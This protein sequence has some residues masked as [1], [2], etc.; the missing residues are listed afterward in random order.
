MD[1]QYDVIVLGTGLTECILSGLLS[2]EGKKVLHIDRNDYYGG[3]TASLHL[4]QL[5]TKFKNGATAPESFGKERDF[6]V[7]LIPKFAMASG[8]F[9]DILYHTDVTRYLEFRQIEGSFVYR[10]GK[11]SKVP[12]SN[13]EALLSPLMSL[14]EKNRAKNF[15][16]FIQN[17]DFENP[18]THQ[19][20]DLNVVPMSTIYEKFGLEAGTQ[21]F[22]GHALAL[23][24]DDS[25]K[26]L[27]GRDTYRRICLYMNSMVRYGKSPY[28]YPVHGLGE[29]PQGFARLSAIHGGTYMLSK[30][31]DEIIYD[32]SGKFTGVKSG[33]EV[34][35][36]NLVIG[37]ASYFSTKVTKVGQVVRVICL[38]NHPIPETGDADSVQIVIPQNQIGRNHDIYIAAVSSAHSV[39]SAGH[40]IAIVSSIVAS[41]SGDA[42]A[43]VAAGVALL[44]PVLE[45]F[46]HVDDLYEPIADG[47]SDQVFISKSYDATSHFETVC[48]DVKDIYKRITGADLKVEGKVKR[49]EDDE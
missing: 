7:D 47:S 36:A 6:N 24:L 25:Y 30:P 27:P 44:G 38:L 2:V 21:D 5:Y 10:D 3:S 35:K 11:I 31:V 4:N 22:I 28:I 9:V 12:S 29:L 1:E 41:G 14:A 34:A 39:A 37:D 46:V 17:Y 32:V 20:L 13:A 40:Y 19:G 48:A 26:T 42:E 18:A 45:K 23:H 8:E 33:S 43:E 15:F 16:E 49:I